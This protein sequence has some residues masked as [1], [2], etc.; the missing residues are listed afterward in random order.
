MQ[1]D[2]KLNEA[3]LREA[4]RFVRPKSYSRRM[5]GMYVR[6]AVY[7]LIVAWVLFQTFVR[8]A[9]IPTSIVV[10]RILILVLII[11][12]FFFRYRKNTRESVVRLD[13]SLPD[14]LALSAEG[15][16]VEGPNGAQSFQPWASYTGF[17]EGQHIVLLRRRESDLYN[18][19]AISSR[20]D[21]ERE[22]LRGLLRAHLPETRK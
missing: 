13:S 18:V 8:H 17:R 19:L 11:G 3:E 20:G 10:S 14:T 22:M 16:R 15:V 1:F 7:A 5:A 21:A 2:G 12:F 4:T 9:H 6:I